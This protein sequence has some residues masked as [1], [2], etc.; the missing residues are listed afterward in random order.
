[1]S[2][3]G[4]CDKGWIR[5]DL[6]P[7]YTL[8]ITYE[9]KRRKIQRLSKSKPKTAKKLMD[10]YSKRHRNRVCDFLH[11]LI[12]E[13]VKRF[14]DYEHDF[15]DLEKQGMFTKRKTHNRVI[16]RQN[17]KQI[18]A[19]M[20]YKGNIRLINPYNSTKICPRCVKNEAPKGA[21]S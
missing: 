15:E 2:M 21:G 19:L 1:M 20:G 17:W 10:K 9:N 12:T 13:I 4:F 7:L 5:V 18:I 3:N 14:K 11:K 8:H 6:K 16:S